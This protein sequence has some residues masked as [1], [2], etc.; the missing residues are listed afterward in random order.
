MSLTELIG[1]QDEITQGHGCQGRGGH[2]DD[3]VVRM[4]IAVPLG[5]VDT[6]LVLVRPPANSGVVHPCEPI[7]A[8]R[9]RIESEPSTHRALTEHDRAALHT[10]HGIAAGALSPKSCERDRERAAASMCW[11]W[12]R[13]VLA[14]HD[15][16][17]VVPKAAEEVAE[18]RARAGA[19][20]LGQ[21]RVVL[22]HGLVLRH[23]HPG[24]SASQALLDRWNQI[25]SI[26]SVE[27]GS[28]RTN[29]EWRHDCGRC[30]TQDETRTHSG[31]HSGPIS[32]APSRVHCVGYTPAS[33]GL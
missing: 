15:P 33:M 11:G 28:T 5:R 13:D 24:R 27:R 6:D 2:Q 21:E 12:V 3:D 10:A 29:E 8:K 14:L 25:C 9:Q 17:R 4:G 1:W 16:A 20:Y 18:H 19:L 7:T 26:A 30:T 23:R 22:R 32:F 31:R